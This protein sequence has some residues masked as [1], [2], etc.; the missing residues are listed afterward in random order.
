MNELKFIQAKTV[1]KIKV[2]KLMAVRSDN[3]LNRKRFDDKLD[4]KLQTQCKTGAIFSIP[5]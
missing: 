4:A 3:Y 5:K 1:Y 2:F